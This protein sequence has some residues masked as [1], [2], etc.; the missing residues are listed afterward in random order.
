MGKE[1]GILPR[2]G[3]P[4]REM[5]MRG[6]NIMADAS[7]KNGGESGFMIK[8]ATFIVDRRNLFFL[9]FGIALIVSVVTM[10]WTKVENNLA[11]YLPDTAETSK[12]LDLMEEQFI[13]YGTARVMVTNISYDEAYQLYERLNMLDS[14]IMLDFED[15]S[16]YYN[17]FSAL[18]NIT[19]GYEE[20][21]Q[22]ALGAL[23]EV[24]GMLEG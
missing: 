3:Q 13:T 7:K 5:N 12:G 22:R 9:L 11:A 8:V 4:L 24:K 14:V 10:S 19:F 6:D 2:I 21:D 17:N 23:E 15:S 20:T 16:D 1:D 18:Y